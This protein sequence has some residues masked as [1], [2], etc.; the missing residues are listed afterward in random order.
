MS[1]GASHDYGLVLIMKNGSLRVRAR[2][3]ERRLSRLTQLCDQEARRYRLQPHDQQDVLQETCVRV[4]MR[5]VSEEED[6]GK[7]ESDG[8]LR[9]VARN[10]AREQVR[11]LSRNAHDSIAASESMPMRQS[12]NKV[13]LCDVVRSRGEQLTGRQREA[14]DAYMASES[15]DGAARLLGIHPSAFRRWHWQSC[16][17]VEV[18][19]FVPIQFLGAWRVIN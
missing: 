7:L 3:F 15:I 2:E 19:E 8:W 13:S 1:I 5:L 14:L 18:L 9:M 4:W 12:S 16:S 6:S 10:V 17:R 11:V